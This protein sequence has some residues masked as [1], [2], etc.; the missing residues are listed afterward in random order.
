MRKKTK[1]FVPY[2]EKESLAKEA[3]KYCDMSFEERFKNFDNI[4]ELVSSLCATNTPYR[5]G[6]L[7]IGLLWKQFMPYGQKSK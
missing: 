2:S 5:D 1:F 3:A 6:E 4:M 7:H